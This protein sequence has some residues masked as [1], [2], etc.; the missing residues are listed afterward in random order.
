MRAVLWDLD[1]T[2]LDSTEHHWQA[3]VDA[4]AARG[5]TITRDQYVSTFGLRN[6]EI[7]PRLFGDLLALADAIHLAHDKEQRYRELVGARGVA[8]LPGVASW[9]SRLRAAGWR[10][11]LATS[12][13]RANVEA[14]FAATG[15][16]RAL[17]AWVSADEVRRGKPDPE[18]FL[19]AAA[20]VGAAPE[21]CVVVE[22]AASGVEAARRAG[23]RCIA[24]RSSQP[25]LTGDLSVATLEALPDDAFERLLHDPPLR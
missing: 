5:L 17:D 1:G 4:V 18:V 8:L 12:A 24:V 20:K 14:I 3:W 21:R 15:L 2:L 7:V 16:D 22:D 23:M 10:Q 13:P 9:M 11:A 25:A 6:E 19:A